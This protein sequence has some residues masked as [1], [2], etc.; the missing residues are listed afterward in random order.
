MLRRYGHLVLQIDAD[1]PGVWPFHCHIAWHQSMGMSL[2][3]LERPDDIS[4][5]GQIPE[6]VEQ[7]CKNWDAWTK[8]N[9]VESIDAG[10]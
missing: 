3:I 8:R 7:T 2:N 6:I 5:L 4:K 10:V 1:N 9:T